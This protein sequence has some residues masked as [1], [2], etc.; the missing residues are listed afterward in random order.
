M[1]DSLF[2]FLIILTLLAAI[3]R[4]DFVLTLLYLLLGVYIAGR[5]WSRRALHAVQ[6][7]RSFVPRVFFAEKVPVILEIENKSLLPVVWLQLHES[8][9]PELTTAGLFRRVVSLGPREKMRFEYLLER[10]KRGFY[11]IGPLRLNSGDVFGISE[12]LQAS[13]EADT[14]TVYP[15]MVPITRLG[16][17][18]RSPQGALKH[19][20]PV[21][22]D[23]SRVYGRRDYVA[24]DSLRRVDWKS[25]ASTGRLQVK[26]FEPSI[27]LETVIL[28]NLNAAEYEYRTRI[29]ATELGIVAAAS[30]ASWVTSLRQA[31]GLVTNGVDPLHE[32]SLPPPVPARRGRAHLRRILDVLARVQSAETCPLVELLQRQVLHFPWGTTL[33]LITPNLDSDLFDGLFQA[34]RSGMSVVLVPCGPVPNFPEARRRAEY[35]GFP[36]Y[37]LLSERDLEAWRQ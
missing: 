6:A 1:G 7:R 26:L 3:L 33:V 14:L 4:A 37:P 10:R 12:D 19:R 25:T 35:F 30:I 27:A 32:N 31:V 36:L 29:D 23:P 34:Q 17:P 22:E 16:L 5:L 15:R 2:F 18:S 24:G 13:I 20:L 9:P 28:L 11:R 8:L 21:F